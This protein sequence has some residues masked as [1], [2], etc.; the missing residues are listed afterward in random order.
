MQKLRVKVE[1]KKSGEG[2][3]LHQLA[4]ISEQALLFFT[5]LCKDAGLPIK[6]ANSGLR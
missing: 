4:D 5:M 2:V 6:S 3:K 1:I